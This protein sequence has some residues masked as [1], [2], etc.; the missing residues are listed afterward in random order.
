MKTTRCQKITET[1]KP[2]NAISLTYLKVSNAHYFFFV[3]ASIFA[4]TFE[5]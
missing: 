2:A 4:D 5:V 1:L 3:N